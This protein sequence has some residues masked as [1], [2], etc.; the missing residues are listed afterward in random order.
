MKAAVCR[1]FGQP[2]VIGAVQL[3][4]PRKGEVSVRVRAVGVCHSDLTFMEGRWGGTL[5][6]VYGHEVAGVVAATGAGVTTVR[7]GDHV[8]FTLVRTC[9]SCFYC[10]RGEPTQC[11]G[12]FAIDSRGALK[13]K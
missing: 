8:A 4:P 11:E 2:L 5:P 10:A 13:T 1:K 6:A 12:A 3:A 9:G 7:A